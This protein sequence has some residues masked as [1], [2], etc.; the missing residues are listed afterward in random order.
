[1][2]SAQDQHWRLRFR[3]MCHRLVLAAVVSLQISGCQKNSGIDVDFAFSSGIVYGRVLTL[4][5]LPVVGAAVRLDVNLEQA[6]CQSGANGFS[7]TQPALSDSAGR[8]HQVVS[9]PILPGTV[10]VVVKVTPPGG[11]ASAAVTVGGNIFLR[12]TADASGQPRDSVLV[13]VRL[14]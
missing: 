1:M 7:G 5:G 10:C 2:C 12:L 3:A 4:T 8:Y 14:P 11:T 13:D 6:R 9:A